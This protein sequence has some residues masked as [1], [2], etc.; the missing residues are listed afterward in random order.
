MCVHCF[1]KMCNI[2]RKIISSFFCFAP[3]TSVLAREKKLRKW[4]ILLVPL[5][6][7]TFRRQK[8][9]SPVWL[10]MCV[11]TRKRVCDIRQLPEYGIQKNREMRK[12]LSVLAVCMGR[13]YIRPIVN[14]TDRVEEKI[15]S[16]QQYLPICSLYEERRG[17]LTLH[18]FVR[19][20]VRGKCD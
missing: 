14:W 17:E 9:S 3:R 16:S 12:S 8:A 7:Q 18:I 20:G 6:R 1:W 11:T 4:K 15:P 2:W 10:N 19:R 13:M 5:A